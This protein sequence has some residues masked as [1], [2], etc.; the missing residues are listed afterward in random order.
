MPHAASKGRG[1]RP[2]WRSRARNDVGRGLRKKRLLLEGKRATQVVYASIP[3]EFSYI[4]ELAAAG[5]IR[6]VI[7][8]SVPASRLIEDVQMLRSKPHTGK[9]GILMDQ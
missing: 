8:L 5:A 1:V 6:P 7:D 2:C 3:K 9:V 4:S